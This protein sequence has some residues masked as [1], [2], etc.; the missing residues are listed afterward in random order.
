M[1]GLI[2]V[3]VLFG[4]GLWTLLFLK[5]LKQVKKGDLWG[6][7]FLFLTLNILGLIIS[8]IFIHGITWN[9]TRD[10]EK[11]KLKSLQEIEKTIKLINEKM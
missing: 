8:Y 1:V 6:I 4:V 9:M 2:V 10:M 7:L 3:A 11:E 5:G